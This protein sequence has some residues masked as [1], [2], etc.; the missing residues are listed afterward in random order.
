MFFRGSRSDKLLLVAKRKK[1]LTKLQSAFISFG[2]AII[3]AVLH[4]AVYAI[5]GVEEAVFFILTLLFLLSFIVYLLIFF[6]DLLRRLFK[7]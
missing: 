5:F 1:K 2:L 3:T 4:N 6:A 7:K